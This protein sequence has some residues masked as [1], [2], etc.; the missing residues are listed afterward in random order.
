MPSL[1]LDVCVLEAKKGVDHGNTFF[2]QCRNERDVR[3]FNWC[4]PQPSGLPI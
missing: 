3:F 2:V 1:Y 4:L